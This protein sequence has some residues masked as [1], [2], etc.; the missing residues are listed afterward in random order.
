MPISGR[1]AR[2]TEEFPK[3]HLS[4]ASAVVRNPL[5]VIALFVLLVEAIATVTLVNVVKEQAIAMPLV[6]FIVGFPTLIAALFF[7]TLWW[8]HQFLYSPM[9]YRSDESF[10]TAM[11]RLRRVEARQDAADLNPQTAGESQSL[12]V[13]DRLLSLGDVRGAVK[14]GRTFLEAQ[15]YEPAQRIFNHI[16][17]R[18]ARGHP[19]RYNALA[20]LAYADI[21]LSE[22]ENA[23]KHLN[24]AMAAA[25]DKVGPWHL[26]ALAYG[27]FRLSSAKGDEHYRE[28]EKN[29]MRTKGHPWYSYNKDSFGSLYP[30][31]AKFL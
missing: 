2:V 16:L 26:A 27:H 23:I 30:E 25:P 4:A 10:L 22:Y 1:G 18:S 13:V 6:W 9:E 21:G 28:F 5:S 20:N 15:Q 17:T 24:E 29:L 8:R 14:V 31:I 3:D 19:D 12:S 11:Q 7:A